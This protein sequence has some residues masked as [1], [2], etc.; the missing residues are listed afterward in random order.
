MKEGDKTKRKSM[1]SEKKRDLTG[2]MKIER[3]ASQTLNDKN[4]IKLKF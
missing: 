3:K 2:K 4:D 1:V